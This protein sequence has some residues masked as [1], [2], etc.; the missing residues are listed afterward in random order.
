MVGH[1]L[2]FPNDRAIGHVTLYASREA[3][4]RDPHGHATPPRRF[5]AR[6]PIAVDGASYIALAYR[7][8]D[9]ADLALL[10]SLEATDL[11]VLSCALCT[12]RDVDLVHLGRLTGLEEIDLTDTMIVGPGLWHLR[13][14]PRL[15]HLAL[16]FTNLTAAA[17]PHLF[18]LPHLRRLT[19]AGTPLGREESTS[20]RRLLPYCDVRY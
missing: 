12:V 19:I 1:Y 2:R 14:L 18:A 13:A 10:A 3:A 6:G 20:V 8:G 15:R 16:D 7:A 4:A 9:V 5:D 11:Q 17:L